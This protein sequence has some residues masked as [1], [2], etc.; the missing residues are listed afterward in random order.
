[1]D[2]VVNSR[3]KHIE[4]LIRRGMMPLQSLALTLQANHHVDSG[5]FLPVIERRVFYPFT[6]DL[7][8][9][10]YSRLTF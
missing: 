3:S 7:I 1:M 5:A 10:T 2:V 4:E 8:M 6:L 9:F